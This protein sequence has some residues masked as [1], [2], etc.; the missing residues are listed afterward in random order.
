MEISIFV[1]RLIVKNGRNNSN[2][3]FISK[4]YFNF[5]ISSL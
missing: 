5:L 4:S 1:Y 2:V 3:L